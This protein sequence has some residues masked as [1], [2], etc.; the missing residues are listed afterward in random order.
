MRSRLAPLGGG[1]AYRLD[2]SA[3]LESAVH[4]V[5]LDFHALRIERLES[6]LA[7]ERAHAQ[8]LRAQLSTASTMAL[9]PAE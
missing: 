9:R 6:E 7:D 5:G 1:D 4:K 2:Q 3:A 8:M